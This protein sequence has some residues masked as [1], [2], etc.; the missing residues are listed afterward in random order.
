MELYQEILISILSKEPIQINFPNLTIN[1]KEM[2]ELECYK[3]LQKIKAVLKDDS[4]K[5][6]DCFIKTEEIICLF[7]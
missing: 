4:L 1:A 7:E 5:D 2:I 3:T 6:N